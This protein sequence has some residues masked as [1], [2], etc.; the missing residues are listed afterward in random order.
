LQIN[1]VKDVAVTG[2][3]PPEVLIADDDS[4]ASRLGTH[5]VHVTL[6]TQVVVT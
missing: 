2:R 4:P 3:L 1:D 6:C 5:W